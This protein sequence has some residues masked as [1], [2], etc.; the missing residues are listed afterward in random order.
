MVNRDRWQDAQ[1]SIYPV[2]IPAL[3]LG[4]RWECSMTTSAAGNSD[5]DALGSSAAGQS[6]AV[7]TSPQGQPPHYPGD[8]PA[9]REQPTNGMAI[10]SL[11]FGI[12]GL[13]GLLWFWGVGSILALI[14]GYIARSQIKRRGESGSGLA[15]AGIVL[16]WIGMAGL[17]LFMV[18]L[19]FI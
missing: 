14:F 8:S 18:I 5:K 12:V 15:I 11:I 13:G 1:T 19:R 16:G 17:V 3:C 4:Y 7:P 9:Y 6:P 10:A 2:V